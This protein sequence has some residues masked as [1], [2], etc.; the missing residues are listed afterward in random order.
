M[1]DLHLKSLDGHPPIQISNFVLSSLEHSIGVVESSMEMAMVNEDLNGDYNERFPT[2]DL[3]R[4]VSDEPQRRISIV[5]TTTSFSKRLFLAIFA[6]SPMERIFPVKFG[7]CRA[8]Q[9]HGV[10]KVWSPNFSVQTIR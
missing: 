5:H 6:C 8:F 7:C 10:S 4:K 1:V 9:L 2:K 3:Q